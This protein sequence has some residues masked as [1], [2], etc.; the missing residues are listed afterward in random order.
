MNAIIAGAGS[1]YFRGGLR[2]S[3][4]NCGDSPRRRDERDGLLEFTAT[5]ATSATELRGFTATYATSATDCWNSPRRREERDE[6]LDSPRRRDGLLDSQRGTRRAQRTADRDGADSQPMADWMRA[7]TRQP[8]RTTGRMRAS[9][10]DDQPCRNRAA[11]IPARTD[12]S[13]SNPP[14]IRAT[15]RA[16][17]SIPARVGATPSPQ[18]RVLQG[19]HRPPDAGLGGPRIENSLASQANAPTDRLPT[20][21]PSRRRRHRAPQVEIRQQRCPQPIDH[22]VPSRSSRR[23]GGL[24]VPS[25]SS[26]RRG[27]LAVPSRPPRR[28]GEL[29]TPSRPRGSSR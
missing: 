18:E 14:W 28:R 1:R 3:A 29:A 10:G 26:R 15:R 20:R 27:G 19:T 21:I 12:G 2:A 9:A 23:R 13:P 25:R 7:C 4:M 24:A 5:Y 17:H 16:A 8:F 6:L 11:A 22:A